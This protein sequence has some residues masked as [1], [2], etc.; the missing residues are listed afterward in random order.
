MQAAVK[1]AFIHIGTGAGQELLEGISRA[2]QE[3]I[4]VSPY[5]TAE[6]LQMLIGLHAKGVHVQL[7]TTISGGN[8]GNV[9]GYDFRAELIRQTKKKD[10][11]AIQKKERLQG[12][13]SFL[14]AALMAFVTGGIFTYLYYYPYAQMVMLA[15]V[16]ITL[17]LLYAVVMELGSISLYRYR[18]STIF[19]IR[20]FIDPANR[21]IRNSSKHFIHAKLFIIDQQTAYMGSADFTCSSLMRNYESIVRIEDYAAIKEL[22]S[23]VQQLFRKVTDELDFVDVEEWGRMIYAEAR[24]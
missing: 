19:P 5:L 22:L 20:V 7:I 12:L 1:E 23:E 14:L 15:L 2:K 21:T 4:V 16:V 11:V 13:R 10:P 9:Q 24:T 6:Q 17:I 3:V 8:I 18:Y